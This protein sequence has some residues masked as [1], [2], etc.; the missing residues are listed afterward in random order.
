MLLGLLRLQGPLS[1]VF[2][3]SRDKWGFSSNASFSSF[4]ALWVPDLLGLLRSDQKVKA[5]RAIRVLRLIRATSTNM[6]IRHSEISLGITTK[7]S[8]T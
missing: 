4:S 7:I 8:L 2:A 1:A 6:V 3:M 5:V